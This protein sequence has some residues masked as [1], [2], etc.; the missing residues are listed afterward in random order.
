M[1]YLQ[2][3]CFSIGTFESSN[4]A[5]EVDFGMSNSKDQVI[6]QASSVDG[7]AGRASSSSA[8]SLPKDPALGVAESS[9]REE[10]SEQPADQ[11]DEQKKGFLAYFKTKEFYI[12]V[13]LG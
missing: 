12:T 13:I 6:V 11:V 5:F 3:V 4:P 9:S 2:R 10:H 1:R 7:D 8:R